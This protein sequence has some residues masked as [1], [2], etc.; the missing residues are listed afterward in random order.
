[1]TCVSVFSVFIA[2]C[3]KPKIESGWLSRKIDIDGKLEDWHGEL[4][5]YNKDM[6]VSVGAAND[7]TFLYVC[8]VT[9]N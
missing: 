6:R 9:R 8:L 5:Y 7:D 3:G 1:L 2:G 4:A